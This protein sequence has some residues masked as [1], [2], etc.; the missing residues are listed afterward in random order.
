MK[1][2]SIVFS[3]F[4]VCSS[5][6]F[7][8]HRA[9]N[10]V[11]INGHRFTVEI[12][13]TSAEWAKGLMFREKL[14][15]FEGMLFVGEEERSQSFW[16]KNTPIS[17]DIIFISKDWKIVDIKA[18]TEALSEKSILSAKPAMHVLE[19]RGG[20]ASELGI[21]LNQSVRWIQY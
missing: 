14:G 8:Q 2:L 15:P 10:F 6:L 18:Q 7:A 16:M 3:L 13:R 19:I 17:L 1:L 4:L 21:K 20:R 9:Q 11:E 5:Y 12:A